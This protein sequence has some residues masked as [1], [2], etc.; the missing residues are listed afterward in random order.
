MLSKK[1][2]LANIAP[3][4]VTGR[5]PYLST[6]TLAIGPKKHKFV[7]TKNDQCYYDNLYYSILLVVIK[8]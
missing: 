4:I 7:E 2:M 3:A 1:Q 5:H 6:K 8:I